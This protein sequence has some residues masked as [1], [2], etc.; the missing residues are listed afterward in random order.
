MPDIGTVT[1]AE[2]PTRI[3]LVVVS[4][5]LAGVAAV[6]SPGLTAITVTVFAG[7]WAVLAAAGFAQLL[8]T[9]RSA[10]R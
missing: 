3:I 2:R 5:A 9:V 1:V 10:L 4:L 8:V 7:I 6:V